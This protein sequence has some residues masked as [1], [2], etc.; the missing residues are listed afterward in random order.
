MSSAR[1]VRYFFISVASVMAAAAL[2]DVV[3]P[4]HLHWISPQAFAALLLVVAAFVINEF[5]VTR[6]RRQLV[7]RQELALRDAEEQADRS[8]DA[9]QAAAGKLNQSEARYKALVDSQGDAIFRRDTTGRVTYANE[10]FYQLFDLTPERT[11]GRP[12]QPELHPDSRPPLFGSLAGQEAGRARVRHDQ[13]V[14]TSFG[15]SW[16]AWEDYP[17]RDLNG[18]LVEIQS[19]GRDITER[20][21]LEEALIQARDKAEAASRAKSEFLATMSH[22]IRTPMNGVLGMA[23]LLLETELSQEQRTYAGAIGQSGELLM[24]LIGDLL[25]FS[26]IESGNLALEEGEV[27]VRSVLEDIAELLAPRAHSKNIELATIIAPDV[28][29]QLHTDPLR[30]RQ[31]LTNLIGNA[32]K[33]TEKG[34]VRI[35]A[36]MREELD[37]RSIRFEV[38]DTGVGVPENKREEIFR[39]F[40]QADSSHARRFGG[41]GLGLAISRRLVKAM[42]GAIGVESELDAGSCFWF[43][44]P[45]TEPLLTATAG[46]L[47]GLH[48]GLATESSILGDAI[49]AQIV[50]EGG[51][52]S[53]LSDA[54]DRAS[55]SAI[56]V[57]TGTA[58]NPAPQVPAA[59]GVPTILLVTS[60]GRARFSELRAMGFAGYLVKPVRR[61]SLV[62]Q[63]QRCRGDEIGSG[64]KPLPEASPAQPRKPLREGLRILLAEDNPINL[65]LARE[66]L[67]RRGHHVTEVQSGERAVEAML[68]ATFDLV[69]TDI[70]MPGMDGI[71]ATRAIRANEARLSHPRTP[72]AALT[73]D[74]LE[75]GRK[76]CQDAG[77]DDFL[78]KPIDPAELDLM[79]ARLFPNRFGLTQNA[80][81]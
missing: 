18:V 57:D 74:V 56:L 16:I 2:G 66:L 54:A 46:A 5:S 76:S 58:A 63:L 27:C 29:D 19:V 75:E 37:G 43:T 81:A 45:C 44:L 69:L 48:I 49:A 25:D 30:L 34:G 33:F 77:M 64:T 24:G 12:F 47:A 70:H 17:V 78:T 8:R 15:W 55:F 6:E 36:L 7:Q 4:G 72:I 3:I 60:A 68:S 39:E 53:L 71:Q 38:R 51:T 1:I 14:K 32:L 73:A 42:G 35:E 26:K 10:A 20:K 21:K 67:R 9:A 80:A 31:V 59:S 41:S 52:F 22:E 50:E 13:H 62:A 65:L 61:R 11:L 40:V 79:L 28:P 23:R